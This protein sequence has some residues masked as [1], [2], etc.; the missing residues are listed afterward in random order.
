MENKTKVQC[1]CGEGEFIVMACSGASD[2]G[3]ISDQIARKLHRNKVRKM[4]CLAV[5]ASGTDEKIDEFKDCNLL[6]IDGCDEDCGKKIMANR[7]I[8]NYKYLRL[9][10]LGYE[11][12]KTTPN[13]D[14]IKKIYEE[15]EIIY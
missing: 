4:N 10:D 1:G 13:N 12:G 2:L 11:K 15:T 6:V 14:V 5:A 8:E 3:Y 7:G 9:T